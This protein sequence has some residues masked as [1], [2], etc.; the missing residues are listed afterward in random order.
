MQ[1]IQKLTVDISTAVEE[2]S[3]ATDDIT[4]N[5][6][7]AARGVRQV[8]QNVGEVTGAAKQTASG[9]QA[10][11]G[12]SDRLWQLSGQLSQSIISFMATIDSELAER[13][14]AFQSVQAA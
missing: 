13:R 8:A 6:H 7:E 4:R 10:V 11:A 14:E 9:A 5:V 3:A 12:T 2:Q 1:E